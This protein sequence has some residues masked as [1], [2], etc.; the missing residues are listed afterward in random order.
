VAI[1]GVVLICAFMLE[2]LSRQLP[3][4]PMYGREAMQSEQA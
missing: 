2:I 1:G 3:D 4:A